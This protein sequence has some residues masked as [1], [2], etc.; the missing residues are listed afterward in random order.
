MET[1]I[2]RMINVGR[3]QRQRWTLLSIIGVCVLFVG[4]FMGSAAT[5]NGWFKNNNDNKVPIYVSADSKINEQVTLNGGFSAIAKAVTPAVVTVNVMSRSRQ[6]QL[7][8]FLDPFRDFFDRPDQDE[9]GTPRR[10]STP[11]SPQGQGP[12]RPSGVGSGV[13]VSPDGYI[14]T[15]NH[16]VEGASKVEVELSDRRTFTAKIIGFDAPS[17]VAVIKIEATNLPSLTFGDS[18]KVEVGDLVLAVGNPLSIGQTVTMGI[19]S[20][21]GRRSPV[22]DNRTYED[23]LQTDAAINRGNSGGALVNL[24]GEL[25]GVPSQILSQTGG[26]IGIG[27]AIPAKMARNVMDQLIRGGKVR[28]GKLGVVVEPVDPELAKQFGYNG[29]DGAFVQDVPKG[30]PAD[31]AGVK[32]GDIITEFNGQR[33]KDRDQLRNLASTTPPG[34]TVKFKIWRD[35]TERELTAK[36]VE[37]D[38]DNA[39]NTQPT[40]ENS[41]SSSG[42]LSGVR[43]DNLTPDLAQRLS[44]SGVVVT[45]V[46][47]DS[48]AAGILRRGDVIQT[49]NKQAVTNVNEFNAIMQKADKKEVLLRIHRGG[50][51]RFVVIKAQE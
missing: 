34:T 22:G 27:F 29:I 21:K 18:E 20:A 1:E 41:T 33:I 36:L 10:R 44:V 2:D 5:T 16:V 13:I 37:V 15:N 23:F 39:Q 14:L 50:V 28:R 17:D 31:L 46:D 51:S 8:N 26:N 40:E 3:P 19:I 38:L 11:R 48:N 9:E 25:I 35:G 43:V 6:S 12:L 24:R 30:D 32:P 47:P 45:E 4:A 42:V 7:P 49:I